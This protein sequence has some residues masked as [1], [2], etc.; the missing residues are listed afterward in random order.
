M[1][2]PK[3]P[4]KRAYDDLDAAYDYFNK[5]L[6]GARLPPCLI[7]VRPHR[8]AFGYFSGERFG[9]ILEEVHMRWHRF[10]AVILFANPDQAPRR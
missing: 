2:M 7:T 5:Q 3:T 8:G 1:P 4:T 9:K 10:E 6:F